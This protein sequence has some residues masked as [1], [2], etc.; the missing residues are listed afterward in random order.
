MLLNDPVFLDDCRK[1]GFDLFQSEFSIETTM[2]K[3]DTY[4][5]TESFVHFDVNT[6]LTLKCKFIN[7]ISSNYYSLRVCLKYLTNRLLSFFQES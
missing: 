7:E 4:L 2:N 6:F 1:K 3:L 5:F